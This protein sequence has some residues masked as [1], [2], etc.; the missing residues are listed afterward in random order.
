MLDLV[1]LLDGSIPSLPFEYSLDLAS[2]S[3]D[4]V[5]GKAEA[6]GL[7]SNHS[8]FIVL[9]G[10]LSLDARAVCARCFSEFDYS[11]VIPLSAK[12]AERLENEDEDEFLLIENASLDLAAFIESTLVLELPTRFLCREDCRGL[13]PK[14]GCDLNRETCS[15]VTE[16]RDAR[17]DI[18]KGYSEK[19]N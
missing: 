4:I 19:E 9:E 17:W 11:C 5:S 8:G 3:P 13:C 10:G 6:K 12:L 2:F 15:C 14:C 16:D 7:I 18:L 1:R